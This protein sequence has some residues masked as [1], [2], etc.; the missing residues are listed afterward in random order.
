MR[1]GFARRILTFATLATTITAA[2]TASAQDVTCEKGDLEVR[3]LKFTG[4][5]AVSSAEL[6]KIIVTTPSAWARRIL[7]LPFTIRRCLDRS[8][9]PRDRARLIIYY[10]K[11]GFPEVAVDTAVR[12]VGHD[13]VEVQFLIREGAPTRLQ[14]LVITGLDSV[15]NSPEVTDNLPIRASQRFDRV[16]IEAA[17]DTIARRLRNSG[18]PRAEAVN[19]FVVDSL[20]LT[21]VDTIAISTGPFTRLGQV[22]IS[23]VPFSGKS[24]QI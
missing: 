23:V 21:A 11:R 12:N 4:N 22:D 15:R 5:T 20:Q 24:Q 16:N 13:G 8:E 1:H 9:L 3:G 17:R 6:S 19:T 7:H 14:S 10:R 18:Y 2:R